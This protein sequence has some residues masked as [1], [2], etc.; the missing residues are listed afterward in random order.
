MQKRQNLINNLIT[1]LSSTTFLVLSLFLFELF[2]WNITYGSFFSLFKAGLLFGLLN[3]IVKLFGDL[4]IAFKMKSFLKKEIPLETKALTKIVIY[5]LFI[6]FILTALMIW[7][8]L[9]IFSKEILFTSVPSMIW[10]IVA[11]IICKGIFS[12]IVSYQQNKDQL[13]G[14]K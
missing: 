2:G 9:E 13:G 5:K 3:V 4:L 6:E 8:S 11:T 7:V 14:L 12:M 10:L 1:F